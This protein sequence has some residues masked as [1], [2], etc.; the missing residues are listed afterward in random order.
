MVDKFAKKNNNIILNPKGFPLYFVGKNWE[1]RSVFHPQV[2][3][4]DGQYYLFYTGQTSI[5]QLSLRLD[6]GLAISEDLKNWIRYSHN[7]ILSPGKKGSWDSELVAH[8]FIIKKDNLYYMFYDGSPSREWREEIGLA[9]SKDLIR[10]EKYKNNPVL[11]SNDYWWDKAHVSRC[12][13]FQEK[14]KY[15]IYFA[16]N[17][18]K[19]HYQERIGLA[20]SE[21]L[22]SWKK[23]C[24]EPVLNLGQKD[25]WDGFHIADPRVI[26]I[27]DLFLMFYTGYDLK[28]RGRIGLAFSQNLI[29]WTKFKLNPVLNVGKRGE[30][31]CD[32]ACR[33]DIF[34]DQ[35]KYFIIYSGRKGFRF[36]IG[37]AK[38]KMERILSEIYAEID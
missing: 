13:V 12:C 19:N 30:W 29:N 37:L 10:W 34:Q 15:Y 4:K 11:K 23:I 7:P 2:L 36:K 3:K 9:V 35:D 20:I 8:S 16:G 27:N 5:K 28:K 25:E 18:G 33:A 17:V 24:R 21:D 38:I 26:K 14:N 22:V 1:G 31:D 32:E 6:I